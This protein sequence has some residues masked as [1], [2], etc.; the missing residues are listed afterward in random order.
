MREIIF[1]GKR[2]DNNEWV[3]G[4]L[5][6]KDIHHGISILTDGVINNAV[7]PET[8]GQFTG[9][10]DKNGNKIFE[11]DKIKPEEEESENI[12]RWDVESAMFVLDIYGFDYHIGEGSQ[13][14]YDNEFSLVDTMNFRD[15]AM[16]HIEVIGNIHDTLTPNK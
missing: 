9:L 5:N 1:R 11:G 7:I 10:T 16:E 13:E 2:Q 6:T 3:Y 4:S 8:V 15:I 14:V 12:V